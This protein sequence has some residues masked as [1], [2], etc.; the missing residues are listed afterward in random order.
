[1]KRVSQ[2]YAV[3]DL[4]HIKK[5]LL[6]WA[7][8]FREVVFLDSN[9]HKARYSSYEAVLA[10]DAFT[11]LQTDYED[12]FDKLTAYQSQTKDWLFGY[13]GYDLKN[14]TERLY[15]GNFDGL[16]FPDL[17]FFQPKKIIFLKEETLCFEYLSVCEDEILSDFAEITATN[18]N[19]SYKAG[20]KIRDRISFE[21]YTKGFRTMMDHIRRGDIYEAN[22]CIEFFAEEA[23]IEPYAVYWKLNAIS[24]PPFATFAK[25]N[26]HYLISASPERYLKKA[27]TKVISQP[28]K[29]TAKR[30]ITQNEDE[31]LKEELFLN[32]KERSENVM[33]VDLVRNDLSRTAVKASVEVEELFGIYSFRQV[34]QMISTVVSAVPENINPVEVIRSTFPMGSMTGAPK[35]SA[36][37]IIEK[38]EKTK[39]GLYSGALG[40]FTPQDDFDFNVIIR[41]IL[42]DKVSGYVSF[43][44]GSAITINANEEDEYRECLLKAA[45]MKKVLEE[46]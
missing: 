17:L 46:C 41:S 23:E 29:G 38:V 11:L 37:Q 4:Q 20:L 12:G 32:E 43:S 24:E 16:H 19:E 8:Q 2:K 28:I 6:Q 5:Q 31:K 33:I 1:M 7:Q 18:I 30:G 21:D 22:Y 39:R 13:L 35:H 3:D 36:M 34:H 14:D 26:Q 9:L 10:F 27:G 40:Y 45:A 44:V 15:S 25:F 42:Y